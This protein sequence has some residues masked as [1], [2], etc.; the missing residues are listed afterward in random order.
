MLWCLSLLLWRCLPLL[1]TPQEL[2]DGR[3]VMTIKREVSNGCDYLVARPRHPDGEAESNFNI[4][5]SCIKIGA[6]GYEK[7][8]ITTPDATKV[9]LALIESEGDS[10]ER[11]ALRSNLATKFALE[12]EPLTNVEKAEA[13]PRIQGYRN[14]KPAQRAK[15]TTLL[16][17][18]F[19]IRH[20]KAILDTRYVSSALHIPELSGSPL[21]STTQVQELQSESESPATTAVPSATQSPTIDETHAFETAAFKALEAL[22]STFEGNAFLELLD[23]FL[24]SPPSECIEAMSFASTNFTCIPSGPQ[25]TDPE[26]IDLTLDDVEDIQHST[27]PAQYASQSYSLTATETF[28][29]FS[30]LNASMPTFNPV[31]LPPQQYFQS[32]HHFSEHVDRHRG[33]RSRSTRVTPYSVAARPAVY[34]GHKRTNAQ[35][36]SLGTQAVQYYY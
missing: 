7:Y 30:P 1:R 35:I 13:D 9:A 34:R 28:A 26:V 12:R 33:S 17:W 24:P 10:K 36:I 27:P 4:Q 22:D 2:A 19:T 23:S 5:V 21:D 15:P 6:P 20:I 8:K 16:S 18:S 14:P 32:A 3:R 31:T 25:Q 29:F 11:E